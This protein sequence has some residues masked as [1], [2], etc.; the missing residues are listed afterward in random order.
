MRKLSSTSNNVDFLRGLNALMHMKSSSKNRNFNELLTTTKALAAPLQLQT[1][2]LFAQRQEI[3]RNR[4]SG[5]IA[6]GNGFEQASLQKKVATLAKNLRRATGIVGEQL[7]QR[8]AIAVQ[9]QLKKKRAGLNYANEAKTI[10]IFEQFTSCMK[11]LEKLPFTIYC[12]I[13]G[14]DEY[15]GT[16]PVPDSI[17]TTN[18]PTETATEPTETI[19]EPTE[20]TTEP[21]TAP[22]DNSAFLI[23]NENESEDY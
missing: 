4:K 1:E 23:S 12:E 21:N 2:K 16:P 19:T 11:R 15:P 5:N 13:M 3:I 14:C 10:S 17:D 20:T 18:G 9:N 6:N 8:K 7:Q 22:T